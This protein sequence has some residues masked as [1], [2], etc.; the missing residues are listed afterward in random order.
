MDLAASIQ[1]VL[2]EIMLRMTRALAAE[3]GIPNLCMAAASP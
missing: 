2:E 1:A 3:T